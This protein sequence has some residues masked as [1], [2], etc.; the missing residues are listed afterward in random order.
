ML[1]FYVGS[2][3][4]SDLWIFLDERVAGVISLVRPEIDLRL[5]EEVSREYQNTEEDRSEKE[6]QI[7]DEIFWIQRALF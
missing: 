7:N 1:H 6:K 2:L 5:T 4:E 3:T